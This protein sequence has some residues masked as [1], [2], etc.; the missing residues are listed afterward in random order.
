MVT[1][2]AASAPPTPVADVARRRGIPPA[3]LMLIVLGVL[4]AGA[5]ITATPAVDGDSAADAAGAIERGVAAVSH[6]TTLISWPL[7]A[8]LAVASVVHYLAAA[9]AARAAAGVS[10]PHGELFAAQ[11]AA[12]AANR[13]TPAGLGGAGVLARFLSRRGGLTAA[14]S[15]AAVS[16]LAALGGL[17]DVAAFAILIAGAAAFGVTGAA[18]EV[19]HLVAQLISLVPF[20]TSRV[21]LI[22]A[23]GVVLG[24]AAAA[25][26]S[27]RA[28]PAG[29]GAKA[30]GAARR[31]AAGVAAVLRHPRR[32]AMLAGASAATTLILAVGFAAAAVLGP[33]HLAV[34]T[35][36][37]L[38]IGYMVAAAA[39]N[40][41][42][43]PGGIGT[44]D[45]AFV[46][47]LIAA[48]APPGSALAVVVAFRIITFWLPALIGLATAHHLRR[49]GAL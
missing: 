12:S 8:A 20:A 41:V 21:V 47:V 25:V 2:D 6:V 16:S 36:V 26:V 46:G 3:R 43:T 11:F 45:A 22:A 42:P 38:M 35:T 18:A 13:L 4:G 17:S 39:G 9:A 5:S 7:V 44:T 23:A 19:P 34:A 48:H 28:R 32:L 49:A 40:A 31:F 29:W 1:I 15:T 30:V 14:Q 33:S 27:K 10:L 37:P 24:T